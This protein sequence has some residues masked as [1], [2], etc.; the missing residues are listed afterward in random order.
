MSDG[1]TRQL[2]SARRKSGE[3]RQR[4]G[5]LPCVRRNSTA[6]QEKASP[7]FC[8][9]SL[10]IPLL[11]TSR[12]RKLFGR[13]NRIL[14]S[15]LFCLVKRRLTKRLITGLPL[16]TC[17][18]SGSV[19]NRVLAVIFR[20]QNNRIAHT[21]ISPWNRGLICVDFTPS[22]I[23]RRLPFVATK[24]SSPGQF[25]R[26]VTPSTSFAAKT[27]I[28]P[29]AFGLAASLEEMPHC[30]QTFVGFG[31]RVCTRAISSGPSSIR[32]GRTPRCLG[33]TRIR[34]YQRS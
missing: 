11:R 9:T 22:A 8:G 18:T 28:D 10:M 30:A 4:V 2:T 32:L 29:T 13:S 12:S 34:A 17:S 20:E 25:D 27:H 7:R 31:T 16:F 21:N 24:S 33:S 26:T 1:A 19:R 5:W 23:G 6:S 15:A 14:Q 3:R